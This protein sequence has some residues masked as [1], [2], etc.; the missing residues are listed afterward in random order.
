M[1]EAK[2]QSR[3]TITTEL[4]GRDLDIRNLTCCQH[5]VDSIA[6]VKGGRHALMLSKPDADLLQA[7]LHTAIKQYAVRLADRQ[8]GYDAAQG[9]ETK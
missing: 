4:T 2:I 1:I 3:E 5:L 7:L 6:M 9:G 8:D